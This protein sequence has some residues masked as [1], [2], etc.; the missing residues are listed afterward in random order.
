[1]S[2]A[3]KSLT[4]QSIKHSHIIAHV[5]IILISIHTIQ[6]RTRQ[7]EA[8]QYIQIEHTKYSKNTRVAPDI[9]SSPGPGRNPAKFSYPVP[10][11]M[12]PDVTIFWYICFTV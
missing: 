12:K 9:I 11:D 1:M 4:H 3:K 5:R 10:L 8:E 7:T 2:V 6:C